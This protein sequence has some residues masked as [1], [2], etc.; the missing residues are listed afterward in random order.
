MKFKFLKSVL[1]GIVLSVSSFANAGIISIENTNTE[2]SI[3]S[4]ANLQGLEWLSLDVTLGLSRTNVENGFIGND[5]NAY[6]YSSNA[7]RLNDS[8][9]YATNEEVESLINSLTYNLSNYDPKRVTVNQFEAAN[10]FNQNFGFVSI[11]EDH[12]DYYNYSS[13]MYGHKEDYGYGLTSNYGRIF[14]G[15]VSDY[16]YLSNGYQGSFTKYKDIARINHSYKH[17]SVNS[18]YN[19]I[20]SMLVR[21]TQVPEPSTLAIFALGMIGLSSRRF[22]K[23]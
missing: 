21:T 10:W 12:W 9:R 5:N 20:G 23:H 22:K 14:T 7:N 8:W 1:V 15:Y 3:G 19:D 16:A 2:F 18:D 11:D 17:V 13:F 4:F 6:S